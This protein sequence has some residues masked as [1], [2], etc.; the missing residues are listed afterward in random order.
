[1]LG[2]SAESMALKVPRYIFLLFD[3]NG[4]SRRECEC[5]RMRPGKRRPQWCVFCAS[6]FVVA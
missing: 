2:S 4:D 1:M 5:F 3:D 6:C